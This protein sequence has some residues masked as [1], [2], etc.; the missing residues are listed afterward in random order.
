MNDEEEVVNVYVGGRQQWSLQKSPLKGIL[1]WLS[2]YCNKK[3]KKSAM[4]LVPWYTVCRL[5]VCVCGCTVYISLNRET[6]IRALH[7]AP[8]C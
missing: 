8:A 3:L 5:C 4:T 6:M 1:H 2:F 7:V